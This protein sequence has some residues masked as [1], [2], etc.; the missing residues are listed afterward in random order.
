[1]RWQ[2]N[3]AATERSQR[4]LHDPAID[5]RHQSIALRRAQEFNRRNALRHGVILK[6]QQHFQ[7]GAVR[8]RRRSRNDRLRHQLEAIFLERGLQPL[9]PLNF[10]AMT[11]D[12]FIA[13][14]V[15]VNVVTLLLR[16]VA[17]RIRG[18]HQLVRR[19]ALA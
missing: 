13:R 5:I 19:A 11:C 2:A 17:G 8:G 15:D 7:R 1:M 6:P 14:R 4:R 3:A 12:R 10:A 9:Q 18:T 16:D